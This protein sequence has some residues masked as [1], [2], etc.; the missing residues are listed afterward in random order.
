MSDQKPFREWAERIT[1]SEG[2]EL[3]VIGAGIQS[4]P[5]P[6]SPSQATPAAPGGC[7]CKDD[8]DGMAI[9]SLSCP[10]EFHR[11]KAKG[12][13]AQPPP[14]SEGL[15]AHPKL[16]AVQKALEMLAAEIPL[17]RKAQMMA[18]GFSLDPSITALREAAD[19]LTA[20][21][22]REQELQRRHEMALG[23]LD[24]ANASITRHGQRALTAE[25]TVSAQARQIE[26]LEKEKALYENAQ[27]ITCAKDLAAVP[28]EPSE[29]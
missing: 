25:A 26:E 28:E 9:Y 13:P 7:T 22:Q 3:P 17:H 2:D 1:Q 11:S 24:E 15:R 12:A 14:S 23:A 5:L 6:S 29:T 8:G 16:H 10:N 4:Q 21:A 27:C 20:A 19:A 18:D